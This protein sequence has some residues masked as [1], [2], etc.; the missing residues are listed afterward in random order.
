MQSYELDEAVTVGLLRL[1]FGD[2]LERIPDSESTP[3]LYYLLAWPWAKLF[4]TGEVGLRS[5]S[6]LMGTAAVP[7][8]WLAARE[9]AGGFAGVIA[10]ALMATNPLMVW[11]SQEARSYALLVLLGGLSL[12]FLALSL[13]ALPRRRDLALWALFSALALC[14]HY[15]AAFLIA[16]EAVWLLRRHRRHRVAIG[17]VVAVGAVA[18][19]LLPLALEQR[20]HGGAAALIRDSG[21]LGLRVGQIPKQFLVGFDAPAEN[22]LAAVAALLCVASV[23]LL[24]VRGSRWERWRAV[25]PAALAAGALALPLLV[26]VAGADYVNARN[27]L[28]AWLP[29][30]VAVAAGLGLARARVVGALVTGALCTLGVAVSVAVAVDVRYQRDDWRAVAKA[31]GPAHVPRAVAFVPGELR[32]LQLYLPRS[33]PM[34]AN[35]ALVR[36]VDLVVL[37]ERRPGEGRADPAIDAR[38]AAPFTPARVR[39]EETWALTRFRAGRPVR[40]A[41]GALPALAGKR[42][43]VLVQRRP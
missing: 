12:L 28:A 4:G 39:V 34:P 1:D 36:E 17:A 29:A 3:P 33:R 19:L 40:V 13:R 25:G 15:F 43:A 5:L 24:W 20:G 9:L 32:A 6:A 37:A 8:A 7:V 23:A 11:E 21:S 22:A 38:P 14:T 18:L 27:S 26:A 30:A 42:P 2:M 35:G 41:P 10:A 16:A 31:L